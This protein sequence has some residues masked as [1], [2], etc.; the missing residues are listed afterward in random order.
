MLWPA[1]WGAGKEMLLSL[2]CTSQGRAT[3]QGHLFFMTYSYHESD[4]LSIFCTGGAELCMCYGPYVEACLSTAS[5]MVFNSIHSSHLE[6]SSG[7][8]HF[9][10]T[11]A[12]HIMMLLLAPSLEWETPCS[13]LCVNIQPLRASSGCLVPTDWDLFNWWLFKLE[14]SK[15]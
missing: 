15:C 11:P 8:A 12:M 13:T 7:S 1:Q 2:L 14:L 6:T 4:L 9:E 3:A 10:N 5:Q